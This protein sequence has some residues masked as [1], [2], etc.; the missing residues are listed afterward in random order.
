M[1]NKSKFNIFDMLNDASKAEM[2][3]NSFNIEFIDIK[4]IIPSQK[5]FYSV[6]DVE[7]LKES[8][9]IYGLQQ[10]LLIRKMSGHDFYELLSGERRYTA[11]KSLVQ[12]GRED[13]RSVP[14]KVE[15]NI[16]DIRAELQLIFANSTNRIISDYEKM[17]QATKLKELLR[18]LKK[19]G[20]ELSGR[21]RDIVAE[22]LNISS[23]QVAR[24]ESINNNLN[25]EFKEEFKN[26]NI[27]VSTASELAALPEE[28]QK[29]A[30][31]EYKVVKKF[32][33]KDAKK[34]KTRETSSTE[35]AMMEGQNKMPE[36]K[37]NKGLAE[38]TEPME[39]KETKCIDKCICCYCG[40]VFDGLEASNWN[41]RMR[42][43]NCSFCGRR[44][45]VTVNIEFKCKPIEDVSNC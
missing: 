34:L 12:E 19:T 33:I 36:V 13:L 8:I 23:T 5:N 21:L 39:Y 1:S 15:Y 29:E 16:D 17:Q 6:E 22:S 2:S 20:V 38:P 31:E 35:D 25:Q 26:E 24:F 7:E 9:K 30:Y 32:A 18:E 27:G 41:I 40:N 4:K 44:M 37:E 42:A 28:T 11:L 43:V 3:Q 45:K 10:N 14:C